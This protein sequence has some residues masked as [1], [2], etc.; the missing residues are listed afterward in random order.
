MELEIL[1]QENEKLN[2]RLT[3]AI[4]VFKE[5]N[6]KIVQLES[7]KNSLQEQL[8]TIKEDNKIDNK[9][10][11]DAIERLTDEVEHLKSDIVKL[12]DENDELKQKLS[13]ESSNMNEQLSKLNDAELKLKQTEDAYEELRQKYTENIN[14]E[15]NLKT[16]IVSLEKALAEKDNK[17]FALEDK[18][19]NAIIDLDNS[20]NALSLKENEIAEF[21]ESLAKK[22]NDIDNLNSTIDDI[23]NE[24]CAFQSDYEKLDVEYKKLKEELNNNSDN[25]QEFK[26]KML[27]VLVNAYNDILHFD[28]NCIVKEDVKEV[29]SEQK[30]EKTNDKS[31]SEISVIPEKKSGGINNLF[32]TDSPEILI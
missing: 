7:E 28:T 24:K 2:A 20:N 29:Q 15:V 32:M 9:I 30:I 14:K 1:K 4:D 5:Q 13:N 12:T 16:D 25:I 10:T 11:D 31:L 19:Q 8:K 22:Q 23:I 6:A 27:D 21:K 3:K 17:Y 26:K 18:Y